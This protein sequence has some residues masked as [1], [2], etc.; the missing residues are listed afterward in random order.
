MSNMWK[1][2]ENLRLSLDKAVVTV[3][4]YES[5][6]CIDRKEYRDLFILREFG[7]LAVSLNVE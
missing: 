5:I 3:I 2:W 1:K 7:S 6:N 4:K